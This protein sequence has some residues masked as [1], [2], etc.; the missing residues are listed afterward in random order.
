MT[1]PAILTPRRKFRPAI[2]ALT[3]LGA[4]A[5]ASVSTG[6][7][8]QNSGFAEP[9]SPGGPTTFRRLDESQYKR[10]IAQIFGAD[11]KVPGR[12]EPPVRDE[13]LLAIGSA[14][15]I[16]TPSGLEQNAVRAREISTEVLS[17]AKRGRYVSCQLASAFDSP[18]AAQ[19]I[20]KYGRLLFRRP[21][22]AQERGAALTLSRDV[23]QR[24]GSFATGLSAGLSSLLVSPAFI[25]RV[26]QAEADPADKGRQ[27]LD[28]WS[29]ASRISFLLW[30]APPDA[31]LLDAAANGSL[32]TR[33]GLEK[34]VDR[35]L[36]SPMLEDG[37]RAFFSDMLGFD[38]FDG[39]SKDPAIF[40]VFNPRLR[41]DAKEQSLRTITHHLL[42]N[43][44]DYRDLF[45]TRETFLSRS[46]GA[47]YGVPVTA[48]ALNGWMP[49]TFPEGSPHAGLLTFPGFLLLDPSHEGRS[50]PTIRGK[51]VREKFLC[52][53]VPNPPANVNFRI[54]QDTANPQFKTAR[55]RLSAH[56]ES[57]ACAGC[58]RITDPIGLALENYD[59]VGTYRTHENGALID[60]S[61]KFDGKAY[62]NAMELTRLLHDSPSVP[63]CVVQRTFEYGTG[64]QSVPG[65]GPW[66]EALSARF[67]ADGYRYKALL[68]R[69]ATSPAF[70]AVSLP[71][72]LAPKRVAL[73][74]RQP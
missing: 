61:G 37:V 9:R 64:R 48:K 44:A 5:A 51:T 17:E 65:E 54:V 22:T 34:Q 33:A 42:T 53:T 4:I 18:C 68:R 11:I 60:P 36:A 52:Q 45:T 24:S 10:S 39:L 69:V 49:Y 12:F 67:S 35:L 66:L 56:N 63:S 23:T 6:G 57:P 62:S 7:S 27:R 15:V 46:L 21:L 41:D 43:N 58:H 70:Q 19:F 38:Q 47:L 71:A 74:T 25:F 72:P 2:A 1:S 20:E 29:L 8:A 55:E 13:G 14:R 40:P 26:E 59:A 73:L 32:H 3:A 16:V 30:N 31:E 28:A 50:S